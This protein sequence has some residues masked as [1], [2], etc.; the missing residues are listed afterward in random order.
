[1][2]P[3]PPHR[4]LLLLYTS[5]AIFVPSLLNAQPH[6]MV[7]V[8]LEWHT[9]RQVY[10]YIFTGQVTS[11]GRPCPNAT[12][13]LQISQANQPD[14]L[15]ETVASADGTYQLKVEIPGLVDQSAEW[16]LIAQSPE[17]GSAEIAG[18]SILMEGENLLVVQRPLLLI[19]G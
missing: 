2:F 11:Q 8:T 12:V 7:G 5:V 9:A 13:E 18:R 3:F 19:Q 14:V 17:T 1:M 6:G 4:I 16:K 10:T 15:K